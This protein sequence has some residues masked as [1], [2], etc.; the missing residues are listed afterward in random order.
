MTDG[1][2]AD[3][4][5]DDEIGGLLSEPS[6]LAFIAFPLAVLV[7][8]GAQVF[9]GVT[10]TLAFFRAFF[11]IHPGPYMSCRPGLPAGTTSQDVAE[12]QLHNRLRRRRVHPN[13]LRAERAPNQL[14]PIGGRDRS[15]GVGSE[16]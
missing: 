15:E 14:Q 13:R 7:L 11:A 16:V 2:D 6:T 9:R 12:C 3:V 1:P 10:Y 4:G 5:N 8:L